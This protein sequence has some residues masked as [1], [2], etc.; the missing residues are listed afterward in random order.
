MSEL[1]LGPLGKSLIKSAEVDVEVVGL[2]CIELDDDDDDR[3]VEAAEVDGKMH[4][5]L[6]WLYGEEEFE[7]EGTN[8]GDEFELKYLVE[9][10]V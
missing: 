8:D 1:E 3:F 10:C 4:S 7:V 6:L 5:K 2:V 9:N